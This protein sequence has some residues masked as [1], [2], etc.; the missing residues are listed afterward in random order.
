LLDGTRL[1]ANQVAAIITLQFPDVANPSV[2]HLGEGCDSVVFE[3]NEK[4]VFRF[5]KRAD[6]DEQLAIESRILPV[7]AKQSPLPI[8]EFCFYGQPCKAF[9]YH[10]VGYRKLPGVPAIQ[11]DT[12]ALPFEK[13]APT[14][15]R[16]LSW[17]HTFSLSD[18]ARLGVPRQD[19]AALLEEVRADALDDFVLLKQVTGAGPLEEWHAY[20]EKGCEPTSPEPSAPVL[21]H[22]DLAAEHVLCDLT[23]QELTGI[24]D[25][26]EIAISDISTDVAA[27]F[28]WGGQACVD[29]VSS[30]YVGRFD[31]GV[32]ARARFL[33]A[34]RGVGDVAFGLKTGR[35]EYIEAG[36]RALHFCL[37]LE[38]SHRAVQRQPVSGDPEG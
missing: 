2:A 35:K 16:F 24:I 38:V 3:V 32:L 19:I 34:C 14:M 8:P 17:L 20:F 5:P 27:F 15:G 13:W 7:L 21:V 22:R 29:A 18:A 6:V 9:P 37:R 12:T 25:W 11:V 33:A 10:F 4:W 30:S 26:S 28:H 31:E 23:K 36:I 1:N